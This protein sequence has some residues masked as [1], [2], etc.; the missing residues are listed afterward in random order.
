MPKREPDPVFYAALDLRPS[1]VELMGAA[2]VVWASPDDK[3]AFVAH[4]WHRYDVRET[5]SLLIMPSRSYQLVSP[6]DPAYSAAP[7][8]RALLSG[9]SI[10]PASLH[11]ALALAAR[12]HELGW[13]SHDFLVVG[14]RVNGLCPW[15]STRE[16]EIY[17]G[18]ERLSGHDPP[19][20]F[21][22]SF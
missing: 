6:E 9:R 1:L 5:S 21:L 8:Y 17:L 12:R 19:S 22:V 2:G 3:E 20:Y 15:V 10:R 7:L 18:A 16:D 13:W 11:E 4:G 14:T